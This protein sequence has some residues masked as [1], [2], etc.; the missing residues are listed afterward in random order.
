M[1]TCMKSM[2]NFQIAKVQPRG[3]TYLLFFWGNFSLALLIKVLL[4]KKACNTFFSGEK[5][6]R[7]RHKTNLLLTHILKI[8][9][10][11]L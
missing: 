1:I 7:D 9:G 6:K 3:V 2:N 4:I 8:R 5:K 10:S 11:H